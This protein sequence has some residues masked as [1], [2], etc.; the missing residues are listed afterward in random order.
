MPDK[1]TFSWKNYTRPTPRNLE[2]IATSLRRVLSVIA[3]TT[4]IVDAN[5]W[6]T[7]AIIFIGA[8]LDEL[9]NFFARVEEEYN[10]KISINVPPDMQHKVEITEDAIEPTKE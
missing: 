4:I 10:K 3:G 7:F 1:L 6:V 5:H 8:V 2:S 9:K